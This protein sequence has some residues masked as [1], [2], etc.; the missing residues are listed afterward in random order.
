MK[1][2]LFLF[3]LMGFSG[4]SQTVAVDNTT[5]SPSELV[6]VLL[7]NA[8][9]EI[10]NIEI[11][12]AESVA[13]F[14]NQGG[15]FP[16]SEGVVIRSG[17]AKFSEGPYTGLNLGS[18]LNTNS[19]PFLVDLNTQ[20]G[21]SPLISDV[22]YME[23]DFVPLSS[24]FS[25]DF[26]FASN[27]YGQWQCV[28]SDIFAFLLT[29]LVTGE[30]VNLA[31]VPGTNEPVSIRNIK[32]N[33][34]NATCGSDHP[35]LFSTYT[36]DDPQNSALN[37][38]GYTVVMNAS[39]SIVPG[40]PYKIRLVIG[41]SNDADFDSAIFLSAGSFET[42]LD[43]GADRLICDGGYDSIETGLDDPLYNHVW[44]RD[45]VVIA[46]ENSSSLTVTQTGTYSVLVTKDNTNCSIT[47]EI[48]FSDLMVQAPVDLTVCNEMVL[49]YTY[50][51]TQNNQSVLGIDPDIY[52]LYYYTTLANAVAN[53]P[54]PQ[55]NTTSFLSLPNQT[56]YIKLLDT[57]TGVFCNALYD[58]ELLVNDPITI[59]Q[60]DPI[61]VCGTE[62]FP[63][64]DLSQVV[65]QI[66]NGQNPSDFSI[67]FFESLEDAQLETNPINSP[68]GY[69]VDTANPAPYQIWVRVEDA[70]M[71]ECFAT[72]NFEIILNELPLVDELEDVVVCNEYVLPQL[73]NG[74]YY[75]QPGGT[76][77][78]MA[79]GDVI[80]ESGIFYIFNG[81]DENGCQNESDFEV[82][83]VS[84]MDLSG[85][86]CG[87][88]EIPFPLIGSFYT[89]P[90]GGS[91][92]GQL[93]EFGAEILISQTIYYY[94]KING[95]FCQDVPFDIN[96]LPL[97]PV[98]NPADVV[99][100]DQYALP[101][102]ENGDYFTS[103]GGNG[104]HLQA[105]DVISSTKKIYV[106]ADDGTCTN[107][108]AFW[109]RIVPEFSDM[110]VCGGYEL[111][112]LPVG[113]FFTLPGGHGALLPA[114]TFIE[115]SRIVYYYAETTTSPNCTENTSFYIT[116]V[117]IPEVD[118][119]NNVLLCE[120][121]FYT[122][123]TLV[124]GD[125]FTQ[126]DRQGDQLFPGA[127]IS[128]T[129]T[130]YINNLKNG[131][132]NES[133]FEVEIRPLPEVE[134]FTDIY[135][136]SAF[137]LPELTMGRYFTQPGGGGSELF[138]GDLVTFTRTIYIY[139]DYSDLTSCYTEN[140]FT[141]YIN[142]VDLNEIPDVEACDEYVLPPLFEGSYFTES[143]GNGT[144]LFPGDIITESQEIF[145]YAIRGERF[146][147]TNELSFF[148]EI[149][150]TPVLDSIANVETCGFYTLP[151][152][153]Q[154]DYNIGYFWA[155]DG[156]DEI[157][158]SEYS[159]A[160]G[161]YTI[162][163]YATSLTNSNCFDQ[164]QFEVN[165]HPLLQ[166]NID[167][168]TLCRN[169]ETDEVESPLLLSS[170]LDPAE[171][172]VN[173]YLEGQLVYT[174]PNYATYVPGIYTVE[175][176]KLN[177]EIG[178]QCNYAPTTV[179]VSESARPLISAEVTEPFEEV[180]V[181]TVKIEKGSGIY[182]YQLDGGEFQES[183][184]FYDV[185][186]GSHTIAVRGLTG[187]CG[188]AVVEVNVVHYQKF[189]TPNGDGANEKWNI[190]D[191]YEH[192]GT[193]I[194]VF[195]RYGKHLASFS[196]KSEGWDGT[197]NGRPM[198]S[199]E[200]WFQVEFIDEGKTKI[201]KAH[202]TLKR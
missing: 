190:G 186:S 23:F 101:A 158:P 189:F 43:L 47:D 20:S 11:S 150:E 179:Q 109:V 173:W 68:S 61:D 148:V 117:P 22:S 142:K 63:V 176:I 58:F 199:N 126:S 193:K 184:E 177:P 153:S 202:F 197:Y 91:G 41:D 29:D 66:L 105:G 88:F 98:D 65:P 40:N 64:V 154:E 74:T 194:S 192:P 76:G 166:L 116:V 90:G 201:F 24:D 30:T 84:E 16:I 34:Y 115:T 122:L 28:S 124:H 33:A 160:P 114:G 15:N 169:L 131:C 51:L 99:T 10:S 136:C 157:L 161:N 77:E 155:P 151:A 144:E 139:N 163:V 50:D 196:P 200:Y 45:G 8:C 137:E 152:F 187:V 108:N 162:Y 89:A 12:S 62:G 140:P 7:D 52:Q 167:G 175:T 42:S 103:S 32:D 81:P 48:V 180:A 87:K 149:S 107:Q 73:E 69:S 171:F 145:V 25:F 120:S 112:N 119:L 94:V 181:I 55:G 86:Y 46:G 102:L 78:E 106:F 96:I 165:V 72:T 113:G 35:E 3:V 1:K 2:L 133:S 127:V 110:T 185:D 6:N 13:Y 195:D 85:S 118:S 92:L 19:D 143:G 164:V 174:G 170:G 59:A 93:L 21:Q 178:A 83:V 111:P 80:T 71:P 38:R 182:E 130:V 138:P 100:C 97:P 95:E 134:N 159:L 36:V 18:Q 104:Q 70:Q 183:N 123:P 9:L 125:Y 82:Y 57:R 75:T 121:E 132:S 79:A 156:Q 188:V 129:Q 147:C 39:T 37:M 4:F 128:E 27:E 31:V 146:V 44:S 60:P 14:N 168:G 141:V 67:S 26:L 56:I 54:I 191:L 135:S 198:P 172:T 49:N 5:Y 53:I 17:K